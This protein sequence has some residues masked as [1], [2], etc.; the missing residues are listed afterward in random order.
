MY[1]FPDI[2]DLVESFTKNKTLFNKFLMIH[3]TSKSKI[4]WNWSYGIF[5]FELFLKAVLGLKEIWY[6]P[7]KHTFFA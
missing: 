4:D 2:Y 7:W 5:L 1:S 3:E 6:F